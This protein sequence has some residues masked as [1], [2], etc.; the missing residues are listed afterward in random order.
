M[1]DD[2]IDTEQ[3][4][5]W[6]WLKAHVLPGYPGRRVV[7]GTEV[8]PLPWRDSTNHF[9][10]LY[11]A[12]AY[13]RRYT[14]N[15]TAMQAL[16]K[17]AQFLPSWLSRPLSKD[18][19]ISLVSAAVYRGQAWVI[20]LP[21]AGPTSRWWERR[22]QPLPHSSTPALEPRWI[23]HIYCPPVAARLCSL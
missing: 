17:L 3:H 7:I 1:L 15:H 2:L 19:L 22:I 18:E 6:L 10:D 4:A 5:A 8:L 13:L 21:R 23:W 16:G 12:E 14:G 20:E 11:S 9:M